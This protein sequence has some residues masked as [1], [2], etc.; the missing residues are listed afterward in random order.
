MKSKLLCQGIGWV[1][2]LGAAIT[3]LIASLMLKSSATE[4]REMYGVFSFDEGWVVHNVAVSP[5]HQFAVRGRYHNELGKAELWIENAE[6]GALLSRLKAGGVIRSFA[7]CE[8]GSKF[9]A[10]ADHGAIRVMETKTGKVVAELEG[11]SGWVHSVGLGSNFVASAGRD[12]TFRV[13]DART[14]RELW[15]I[16]DTSLASVAVAPDG[17]RIAG[18]DGSGNLFLWDSETGEQLHQLETGETGWSFQVAFSPNSKYVAAGS[19]HIRVFL[20][21]T[22][23][24]KGSI[25]VDNQKRASAIAISNDGELLA[26]SGPSVEVKVWQIDDGKVLH[27]WP[28]TRT[29]GDLSFSTN[30]NRLCGAQYTGRCHHWNLEDG[31][32]TKPER[33]E[34]PWIQTETDVNELMLS[35]GFFDTWRGIAVGGD[36]E[37]GQSIVMI[38]V[39]DGQSWCKHRVD[40]NGRLYSIDILDNETAVAVGYGGV[41]IR[42]R[43]RGENWEVIETPA[44]HWLAGV[45][46]I[47]KKTGYVVGGSADHPVLWKT[48]DG[49]DIWT[50]IHQRLPED[51]A[52]CQL[53]DVKFL[54]LQRGFA[55]G[56]D[57]LILETKD[58]GETWQRKDA[59]T[60]AW[61]RALH[62]RGDLIHVAGKGVMLRSEDLGET[63][64]KLPIP[65]KRKLVDV[66]FTTDSHGWITNFDGEI[67][68]TH[69]GGQSWEA[70]HI[71]DDVATG[72]H[73]NTE[74]TLVLTGDGQVFRQRR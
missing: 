34:N 14:G 35:T 6:N 4:T 48:T 46:F 36:T 38:S 41:M 2:V 55:V 68:E 15:S 39:D 73:S 24:A 19:K 47:D 37:D 49:G 56:T 69:D 67:L 70:I 3:F 12:E 42:T 10:S 71:H 44:E 8:D 29:V 40:A 11:H 32:L 61:L 5:D 7:F 53:R 21:D 9:V 43:D 25:Q 13:W 45:D 63:W 16:A 62:V 52:D 72:I 60:D 22:G 17:S 54:T 66:A 74:R 57:G 20:V 23:E 50:P 64:A 30:G 28:T 1:R 31:M 58:A 51:T 65:E 59:G 33:N 26:T 27:V 18:T